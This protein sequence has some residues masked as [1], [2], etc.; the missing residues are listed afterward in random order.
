MIFCFFEILLNIL[1]PNFTIKWYQYST[2][3]NYIKFPKEEYDEFY[4]SV[5]QMYRSYHQVS[6][7]Y[8]MYISICYAAIAIGSMVIQY[9]KKYFASVTKVRDRCLYVI[10]VCCL[11]EFTREIVTYSRICKLEF[12]LIFFTKTWY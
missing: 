5:T 1:A 3:I 6:R 7:S 4:I 10:V 12:I 11:F 8:T 2:Y 9:K